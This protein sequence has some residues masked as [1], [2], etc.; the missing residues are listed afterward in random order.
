MIPARPSS[1]PARPPSGTR[2]QLNRLFDTR[3]EID[4]FLE[5]NFKGEGVKV[6]RV[7][8]VKTLACIIEVP[9]KAKA[10]K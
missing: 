1:L 3:E 10:K 2:I 6:V 5:Q 8:E 4:A 9:A 7:W